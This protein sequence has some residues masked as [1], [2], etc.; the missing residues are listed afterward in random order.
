MKKGN[1]FVPLSANYSFLLDMREARSSI[2]PISIRVTHEINN[3]AVTTNQRFDYFKYLSP[4]DL[5]CYNQSIGNLSYLYPCPFLLST[6]CPT[7]TTT[8][9][10]ALPTSR[11]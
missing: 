6:P 9:P 2:N 11:R 1:I 7:Q 10:S 8:P 3:T 5:A 4:A